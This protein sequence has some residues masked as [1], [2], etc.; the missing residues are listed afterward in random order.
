MLFDYNGS[1]VILQ[2]QF[3]NQITI[4]PPPLGHENDALS[5]HDTL[6]KSIIRKFNL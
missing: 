4:T 6:T 1:Q 5:S 2:R 3:T